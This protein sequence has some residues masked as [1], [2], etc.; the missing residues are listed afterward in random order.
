MA[1]ASQGLSTTG[2][3]SSKCSLP[4]QSFFSSLLSLIFFFFS[5]RLAQKVGFNDPR[6]VEMRDLAIENKELEAKVEGYKFYSITYRLFKLPK[7]E[8]TLEDYGQKI[9]YQVSPSWFRIPFF[10]FQ[11]I[12]LN[13]LVAGN[14][15]GVSKLLPA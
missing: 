2:I 9:T 8:R 5:V 11:R 4:F 3:L 6:V 7:L 13:K 10:G 1:S 15:R 14:H 12:I